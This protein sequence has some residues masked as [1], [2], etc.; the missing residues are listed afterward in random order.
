MVRR[1]VEN[2][3]TEKKFMRT[4]GHGST[5]QGTCNEEQCNSVYPGEGS[6]AVI[7]A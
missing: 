6:A 4:A 2:I 3:K 5:L 7:S 1:H